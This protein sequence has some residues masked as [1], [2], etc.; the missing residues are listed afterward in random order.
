MKG[1][2]THS[3]QAICLPVDNIDTDQLIPARFMS[4]P[5]VDGYGDILLHDLRSLADGSPD[6]EFALN[7]HPDATVLIARRNFGTGSSREAAVYALVD[8]G[9]KAVF[10]SGFGD[11]FSANAANNGL[12]TAQVSEETL[13]ALHS[14][15]ADHTQSVHIDL[16]NK[17]IEMAKNKWLFALSTTAQN[18]LVT[19]MDDIDRTRKLAEVVNTFSVQRYADHPWAMPVDAALIK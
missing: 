1:W 7:R 4:R 13:E 19:G 17:S 2:S 5:R 12:L 16:R 15:L 14:L 18:K 3:G 6:P 9:F 11:I 10:A 8:A